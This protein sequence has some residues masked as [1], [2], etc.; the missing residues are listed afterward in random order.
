MLELI[1][2]KGIYLVMGL[3]LAAALASVILPNLF[4]SA[5]ALAAVLVAIAGIYVSL[6]AEFLAMVQILVY[7]GAIM[8]LVIYAIMLTGKLD[9][10]DS[11]AQSIQKIAASAGGLVFLAVLT[12]VILNTPWPNNSGNA[13]SPP[14][15]KDLG[16]RLMSDY[17]FPF[18]VLGFLLFAVLIGALVVARKEKA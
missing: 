16:I 18:E 1:A 8:T 13:A 10:P 12:G 9:T 5:L 14:S 6:G 2:V 15:V 17:V 7:V 3:A 11:Q 4:H